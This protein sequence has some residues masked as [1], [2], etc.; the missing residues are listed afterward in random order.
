[1][2]F[3]ILQ[4]VVARF[5]VAVFVLLPCSLLVVAVLF[6]TMLRLRRERVMPGGLAREAAGLKSTAERQAW[7]TSLP[8]DEAPLARA[9]WHTL[10]TFPAAGRR[11]ESGRLD[12][13]I[14]VAVRNA[15]DELHDTLRGLTTLYMIAPYLGVM[16]A[17]VSIMLAL[18][19]TAVDAEAHAAQ[20]AQGI[21]HALLAT[22]WGLAIALAAYLA[23]R[24]M[25]RRV[26]HYERRLLLPAALGVVVAYYAAAE[27]SAQAAQGK[28]APGTAA[29]GATTPQRP[30][31]VPA[32]APTARS[33]AL[34]AIEGQS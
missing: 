7:L 23:A 16:G 15:A 31:N 6:Q 2:N 17:I 11:P 19:Q 34:D 25:E 21:E 30:A 3:P 13:I 12:P 27:E 4:E 1:M 18:R 32:P 14:A 28:A 8:R 29:S 26:I 5:G 24:W 20:L 9:V 22:L 33:V 10:R